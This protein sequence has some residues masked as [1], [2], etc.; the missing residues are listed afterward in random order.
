MARAVVLVAITALAAPAQQYTISTYAGGSP[1]PTPVLGVDATVLSPS[2]VTADGAGN[3]YFSAGNCVFKLDPKGIMTVVAGNSRAGY[4]GDGG[5]ATSAQL[6]SPSGLALDAAGNLYIAD[7]ANNAVRA[8]SAAGVITTFAGNG[9][10][11]FQPFSGDGGP[12]TAAQLY[13]PE[14]VAVDAAGN[15][16]IADYGNSR[17][18]KVTKAGI[19]NTV[20]GGGNDGFGGSQGCSGDGG[21]ATAALLDSPLGVAVDAT[22]NLYI[23]DC[24]VVQKV[25]TAGV[26]TAI[27]GGGS[28]LSD[29]IAATAA[30]LGTGG[31]AVDAN[32]NLY[33]ADSGWERIR[34]VSPA[35]IINTI[36]GNGTHGFSGDGGSA[37][38]AE[39]SAPAD[40]A[41]D[42]AG[43]VYI[44]DTGNYRIRK[45]SDGI[46]TTI[47]GNGSMQYIGDNGPALNA[48]LS[49]PMVS[50]TDSSGNLYIL[51]SGRVRKI[52]AGGIIATVA[53]NG[54]PAY[55]GDGGPATAA[56]ISPGGAALDAAGNLYITD[57]A[58]NRIRK[59]SADGT[60]S[61]IAGTGVAGFS[62]DGG[63][64]A[65]AQ[66]SGPG[67]IAIDTA[68][69]IYFGDSL[70][71][72]PPTICPFCIGFARPRPHGS[73]PGQ[74]GGD[75]RVRK[76]SPD[77]TIAT[78]AGIGVLGSFGDGG[79]AANAQITAGPIAL[80]A[81]GNLYFSDSGV[82][83]RTVT[84]TGVINTFAGTGVAGFSGDGGP[85]TA[86][87]LNGA[88]GIAIDGSGNSYITD[89]GNERVRMITAGGE[90]VTIAGNGSLGYT[91]D[92]A[93]AIL[94][95]LF[96]PTGVA[97][98]A[99]GNVYF[100]DV[101]NGAVR[102]LTP[103]NPPCSFS[104]SPS[105]LAAPAEGGS[106]SLQITTSDGCAWAV[107]NLP[108]WVTLS[109]PAYGLGSAQVGFTVG[110]N[111]QGY[112]SA[113]IAVAN[114]A[115]VI[116]Q[117]SSNIGVNPN[118]VTNG[119]YYTAPVA[120]GSI[121]TIWGSFPV[122]SP[123]SPPGPV[124]PTG[125]GGLSLQFGGVAAPLFYV[126]ASF[127]NAQIPWEVAGQSQPTVTLFAGGQPFAPQPF[128]LATF[129][130]AIFTPSGL[131]SG[132]GLILDTS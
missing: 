36:A 120:A 34:V 7:S 30:Q 130:P 121:A 16:Y 51:D 114:T 103:A 52:S 91:G 17:I 28:N 26:I 22:G 97:A 124:Y 41:A 23:S 79:A 132:Q 25:S 8:V 29:G 12:A 64:A 63:P 128:T 98:D 14:A 68:G 6:Y 19:I 131:G 102:R 126:S 84:A 95:K 3:V 129:A 60:I 111:S 78:V 58:N 71:T 33:I 35:G 47:A 104:V 38:A 118:G 100:G 5:P 117:L 73:G 96:S 86:A 18:R 115:V 20:A 10:P 67:G 48:Q 55:S 127:I 87:Q 109:A 72:A 116:T 27:A 53:G 94:G 88:G 107:T 113:Q 32:G 2:G 99:A 49:G 76:I 45:V 81:K 50:A 61:T 74:G 15:V 56:G 80:D 66:L 92:G 46:I 44:A 85:A 119:A 4:S 112:L 77:G 123:V 40:V 1:V 75:T 70:V 110:Q 83:I 39:L 11:G 57:S 37:T 89:T 125:V 42:A 43:N 24:N 82:R 31:L 62:G 122:P 54:S 9:V 69:N 90:I 59:V 106:V 108:P 13:Q 21:P 105:S 65:A 93:P 101:G